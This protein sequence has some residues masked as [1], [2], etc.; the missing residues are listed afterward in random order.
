[1][2]VAMRRANMKRIRVSVDAQKSM[3]IKDRS[4]KQVVPDDVG[5][6]QGEPV[7]LRA[8]DDCRIVFDLGFGL[9]LKKNQSVTVMFPC[10]GDY[11]FHVEY[12]VSHQHRR[13][14]QLKRVVSTMS[15]NVIATQTMMMSTSRSGPTGDIHVP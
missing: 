6:A 14:A 15:T 9:V 5:A 1:M 13:K 2:P 12:E 3:T 7:E 10:D 8:D 4:I 11:P